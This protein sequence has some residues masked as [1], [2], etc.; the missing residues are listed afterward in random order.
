L[1][2]NEF[3][4]K[5]DDAE[6]FV[7]NLW[8]QLRWKC[9]LYWKIES[10]PVFFRLI[11]FFFGYSLNWILYRLLKIGEKPKNCWRWMCWNVLAVHSAI[12]FEWFQAIL[13]KPSCEVFS[14]RYSCN[15]SALYVDSILCL[16]NRMWY[17]PYQFSLVH[18][19]YCFVLAA[20]S[21]CLQSLIGDTVIVVCVWM[22]Q[23]VIKAGGMKTRS[24][25]KWETTAAFLSIRL[26]L[27]WTTLQIFP[28]PLIRFE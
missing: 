5:F 4:P 14:Y 28:H 8:I 9:Q 27:I 15:G 2:K 21:H 25:C 26:W 16:N 13:V 12:I 1:V 18:V 19:T 11:H 3:F 20:I 24:F 7:E 6:W 10:V 17:K 22:A 23:N